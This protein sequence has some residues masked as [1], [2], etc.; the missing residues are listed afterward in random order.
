MAVLILLQECDSATFNRLATK[1][2]NFGSLILHNPKW[3]KVQTDMWE[4]SY[5]ESIT[6][7]FS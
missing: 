7:T 4:W 1:W 2:Q 3:Y 6:A 5:I